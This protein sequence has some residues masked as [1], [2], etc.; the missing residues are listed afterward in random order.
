MPDPLHIRFVRPYF[1]KS[2]LSADSLEFWVGREAAVGRVVRGLL[3]APAHYLVTGYSGVGKSSFVSRVIVDWRNLCAARGIDRLLIFNLQLAQSESPEDVVKKLIG[4]V[5][6]GSQDGQFSPDKQLSDRLQLSFIQAHSK[7]LKE[8]QNET[9]AHERGGDASLGPPKLTTILGGGLQFALKRSKESSR[10]LEVEH[11]YNLS[12]AIGDFEAVLHLLAKP[13]TNRTKTLWSFWPFSRKETS[14]KQARIL[15]IFDQIDDLTSIQALAPLFSLPNSSFIVL[16]GIKLKEQ[17]ATA[18]EEGRQVLDSFHEEYLECQ[19]NQAEHIL[20]LLISADQIGPRQFSEF[21]DYLNFTAQGLPRRLFAAI[22]RHANLIDNQFYLRLTE[23]D[24]LRVR[25]GSKLHRVIWKNRKRILGDYIDSVQYYLRDKAL[26]GT[27]H[28]ADRMFRVATFTM[29]DADTVVTQMS[30]AIIHSERQRV[31]RNLL[32]VCVE[33]GLI[34]VHGNKYTLADDI[35]R[36][37]KRI[38]DWLKDGFVDAQSFLQDLTGFGEPRPETT[39][40]IQVVPRPPLP[41]DKPE[42]T[43]VVARDKRIKPPP[44]PPPSLGQIDRYVL[45]KKLGEGGMGAVYLAEDTRLQRQ[46]AVK[47]LHSH[48]GNSPEAKARF[49]R[50]GRAVASLQHRNIVS[51]YDVQELPTGQMALVTEYVEGESLETRVRGE[52]PVVAALNISIQIATALKAAHD[53]G[54]VHRDIKP[55]NILLSSRGEVKLLDFGIAKLRDEHEGEAVT[56][57]GA[58]VGTPAYM[59]P[60]QVMGVSIDPRS[61][62]Y[63]LGVLMY[64]MFAGRNRFEDGLGTAALM[65]KILHEQPSPPSVHNPSITPELDSIVMKCLDPKPENRF[66]TAQELITA[67]KEVRQTFGDTTTYG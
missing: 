60:E 2:A 16:G 14:V 4:K 61:D 7:S 43:I 46:V 31:L 56:Q 13:E 15:F 10:S 37:V 1:P 38:P 36:L 39:G 40:V 55:S 50:E 41:E 34:V 33:E 47:V 57:A 63:S 51:V 44:P 45:R 11:E 18:K 65:M 20:S 8:T 49:A 6:F 52:L 53:Q 17:I 22:D 66:W 62:L 5:Y 64:R 26:R 35:L 19:W 28:L 59:S 32:D 24:R 9:T 67:L 54:I 42:T 12:A 3:A 23:S 30:D 27:Y 25:L 29:Q 48:V 21:R 58:L